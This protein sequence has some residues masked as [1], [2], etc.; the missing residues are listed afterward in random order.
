MILELTAKIMGGYNKGVAHPRKRHVLDSLKKSLRFFPVVAIQGARQTGK[1]FLV[2]ELL[3]PSLK[4]SKYVTFDDEA[5]RSSAEAS[6][7]SLLLENDAFLPFIVDEAQKVPKLF[8]A[9]KL[10]VDQKR[11]PGKYLILG[12]TEFSRQALIRESLTG[13]MGRIKLHPLTISECNPG[14][15][16]FDL[17]LFLKHIELGGL[18]GICFSRSESHRLALMKDWVEL[19]CYR[20][21]QQFKKLKLEGELAQ[22]ILAL[23]STLVEPTKAEISKHL[24]V[25]HKKVETHLEAL[26]QLFVLNRLP[27]HPSGTGKPIYIPFDCGVAHY[28]QAPKTRLVQICLLNELLVRDTCRNQR[29]SEFYYYR[30]TGKRM[31]HVLEHP[32]KGPLTAYE[33]ITHDSIKKPDSELMKAFLRKNPRARGLVLAP[34]SEKIKINE[35]SYFPWQSASVSF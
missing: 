21:L 16:N 10:Q 4:T 24:R 35:I 23:C 33:I 8:D 3:A 1:S 32:S 9:L 15:K 22:K 30:S 2:R 11:R 20:D 25:N 31:I 18:P 7:K 14:T 28:F 12:S 13:R 6:S 26:M 34:I 5:I 27:P 29:P 17:G 19:T